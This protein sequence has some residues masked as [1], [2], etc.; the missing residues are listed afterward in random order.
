MRVNAVRPKVDEVK[1]LI[2]MYRRMVVALKRRGL[3]ECAPSAVKA[4]NSVRLLIESM[5]GVPLPPISDAIKRERAK[6]IIPLTPTLF[7]NAA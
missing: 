2:Y 6:K 3:T 5:I 1:A 4:C 7:S